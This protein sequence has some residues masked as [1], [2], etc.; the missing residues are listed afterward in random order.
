MDG[1]TALVVLGLAPGASA[2]E[3]KAAFRAGAKRTHPDRRGASEAFR[4]LRSAYE[5]ALAARAAPAPGAERSWRWVERAAPP[6]TLDVR[7]VQGR[8]A[9]RCPRARRPARPSFD[10]VLAVALAS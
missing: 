5:A 1:T 6:S 4:L 9:P 8:P 10:E 3:I 7:D 2:S